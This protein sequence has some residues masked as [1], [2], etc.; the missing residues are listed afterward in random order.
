MDEI[1]DVVYSTDSYELFSL[2]YKL[3]H[4]VDVTFSEYSGVTGSDYQ[5]GLSRI[6]SD[7]P[8]SSPADHET[9]LRV[10]KKEREVYERGFVPVR[11]KEKGWYKT[12]WMEDP[13]KAK[14]F[15]S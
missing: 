9:L 6:P 13:E 14:W 12:V 2:Y 15:L 8:V 11:I 7:K 3:F 1:D 4:S 10:L 5:R